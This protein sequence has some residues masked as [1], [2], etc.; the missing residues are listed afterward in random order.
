MHI[1]LPYFFIFK[2]VFMIYNVK[3]LLTATF[4]MCLH[5]LIHW[6]TQAVHL[7]LTFPL[8]LRAAL[9]DKYVKQ[10]INKKVAGI[11]WVQTEAVRAKFVA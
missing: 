7:F 2:T 4:A 8:V 9:S 11:I 3:N 10:G 6:N 1:D 5:L